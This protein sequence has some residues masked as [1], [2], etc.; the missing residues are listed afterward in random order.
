MTDIMER[1]GRVVTLSASGKPIPPPPT[2]QRRPFTPEAPGRTGKPTRASSR[3][4]TPKAPERPSTKKPQG[5]GNDTKK[6]VELNKHGKVTTARGRK[7]N[8][9]RL[10]RRIK[11]NIRIAA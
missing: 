2:L 10:N 11:R 9:N 7:K 4:A 5:N 1:P 3:P 8:R 6:A